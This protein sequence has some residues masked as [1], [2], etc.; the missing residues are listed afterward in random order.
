[1]TKSPKSPFD[2]DGSLL[3]NEFKLSEFGLEEILATQRRNIDALARANQLAVEG[4]QTVARR[5]AE[6]VRAGIEEASAL[7]RDLAQSRT[8]E[9]RVSRQTEAAKRA[10]EQSLS[11]ARE[12]TEIVARASN[13]AVDIINRRMGK[14]LDE[15]RLLMAKAEPVLH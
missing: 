4:M 9:D 6:I 14:S 1:M 7:L 8:T 2:T 15:V 5:Q 13:E 10:L 3:L 12:L 11:N